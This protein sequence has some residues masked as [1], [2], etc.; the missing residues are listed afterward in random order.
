MNNFNKKYMDMS[1]SEIISDDIIKN[2]TDKLWMQSG[3]ITVYYLGAIAIL[4]MLAKSFKN[5][6]YMTREDFL[7]I[8][9]SYKTSD[10]PDEIKNLVDAILEEFDYKEGTK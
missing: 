6:C 4:K 10:V 9:S 7:S 5:P 2:I 8:I 1:K 3:Y